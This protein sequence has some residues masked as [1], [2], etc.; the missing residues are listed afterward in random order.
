[1]CKTRFGGFTLIG[2]PVV[3]A[4]IAVLASI[5]LPSLA[6]AAAARVSVVKNRYG[7]LMVTASCPRCRHEEDQSCDGAGI[8]VVEDQGSVQVEDWS[9][10][11]QWNFT[12]VR[13][14]IIRGSDGI[15]D[16]ISY[17]GNTIGAWIFGGQ[18]VSSIT[19]DDMGTGSSYVVGGDAGN[20]IDLLHGHNTVIRSGD[21]NDI[22]LVEG[23]AQSDDDFNYDAAVATIYCGD[24][25][26]HLLIF[27]GQ[28]T[29]Y[30]GKGYDYVIDMGGT[31]TYYGIELVHNGPV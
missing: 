1:M 16:D 15:T 25:D 20:W 29:V 2:Q 10:L 4:V 13:S 22:I 18:A 19:V 12:G 23:A 30:G 6:S 28:N 7:Q 26:D 17:S 31:N 8:S 14:I 3:I 27:G 24:G 11:R 5:L 9:T 21:G